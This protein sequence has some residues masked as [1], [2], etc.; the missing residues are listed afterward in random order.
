MPCRN[1]EEGFSRGLGR[2]DTSN[3]GC[4]SGTRSLSCIFLSPYGSQ[5]S[6]S[7]APYRS[8]T[9]FEYFF[10]KLKTISKGLAKLHVFASHPTR[11]VAKGELSRPSVRSLRAS[12]AVC[13]LESILAPLQILSAGIEPAS[14]PSEGD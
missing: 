9:P 7:L 2:L 5:K 13:S 3:L 12:K 4:R 8:S 1:R 14:P 6:H 11:A 10:A